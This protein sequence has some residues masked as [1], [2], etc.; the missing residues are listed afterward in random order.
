MSDLK[1]IQVSDLH[2]Q[3]TADTLFR[4]YSTEQRWQQVL[5]HLLEY[6]RDADLLLLTGD[7]VHH[8]GIPAYERLIQSLQPCPFPCLWLP[9]NHDDPAQMQAVGN[10]PLNSKQY[11]FDGWRLLLLD[12]TAKPDGRGGGSLAD[13]ELQF[14]QQQLQRTD[15]KHCLIVMH[16]N[17]VPVHSVWQD[18]IALGNAEHFWHCLSGARTVKGII[19]GHVHQSWH[20]E[21]QQVSL[22]SAPAVAPQFKA[23]CDQMQPEDRLDLTGPGYAVYQL[24]PSGQI[25]SQVVRLPG[26]VA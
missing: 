7:L 8:A 24:K 4:G 6:H 16:H 19:F 3:I 25:T 11:D 26:A 23:R 15:D 20:L 2:L 22:F 9:G 5:A 10:T 12:T 14:L 21:R 18:A 17:P 1:L 13:S